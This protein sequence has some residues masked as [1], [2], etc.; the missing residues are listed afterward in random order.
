MQKY[1]FYMTFVNIYIYVQLFMT[2]FAGIQS[3]T[4][5]AKNVKCRGC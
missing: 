5:A 4:A 3:L 2:I 1:V